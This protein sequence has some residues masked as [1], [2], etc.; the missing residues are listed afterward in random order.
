MTYTKNYLLHFIK[1]KHVLE[2]RTHI[3]YNKIKILFTTICNVR[4]EILLVDK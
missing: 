1:Y 4:N 2:K 3:L